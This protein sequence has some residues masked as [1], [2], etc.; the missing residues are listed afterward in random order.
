MKEKLLILGAMV[1]LCCSCAGNSVLLDTESE[2]NGLNNEYELGTLEVS[3]NGLKCETLGDEDSIQV[4]KDNYIAEIMGRMEVAKEKVMRTAYGAT[5]PRVGVFR[6][7]SCGNY[8][9]LSIKIDCENGN[10]KTSVSGNVGDTYV[11]GGDNMRLEFCMVD[12]GFRY[13]GG[14]FLFEDVPLETM[15]LVRY[16]DTEDGG[17]Q[18]LWS[19]DPFYRDGDISR[20]SGLSKLDANATLAW[21]MNRNMSA[22]GGRPGMSKLDSNATLAW[23]INRNM[24]KWGN[25][26]VGPAG[27]NYGVIAPAEMASGNL[28]FDDEDHNNKNWAQ[29]W[30]GP[31]NQY[32]PHGTYYGVQLDRNTRYHVCLNTDK[33]NFTKLVRSAI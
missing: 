2:L 7:G 6:V 29:V 25:I 14:V 32:E 27:I 1:A 3:D 8:K 20:I 26:P 12:A 24:T 9:Y 16:H 23:N 5:S 22:W 19:D 4:L 30:L 10:S 33:T 13:P 18:S 21:H 11:D 31:Q 17:H 28:Y 15:T